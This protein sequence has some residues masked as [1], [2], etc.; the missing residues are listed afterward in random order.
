M[1]N[2]FNSRKLPLREQQRQQSLLPSQFTTQD[3]R[4]SDR[5]DELDRDKFTYFSTLIFTGVD[6]IAIY[7]LHDDLLGVRFIGLCI[8]TC[9]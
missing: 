9:E 1:G 3:S 5:V 7:N 6:Q 8:F 2:L 4:S